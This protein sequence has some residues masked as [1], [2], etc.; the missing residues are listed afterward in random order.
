MANENISQQ[1]VR[2]AND[3]STNL[4]RAAV[5]AAQASEA[6]KNPITLENT[7]DTA[8]NVR[9]GVADNQVTE[10]NQQLNSATRSVSLSNSGPPAT[11]IIPAPANSN[12]GDNTYVAPY[13][14]SSSA[15]SD[16]II[17]IDTDLNI[18]T[19][20]TPVAVSNVIAGSPLDPATGAIAP[21]VDSRLPITE[22]VSNVSASAAPIPLKRDIIS[23]AE[24]NTG[25]LTVTTS[26]VISDGP[27]QVQVDSTPTSVEISRTQ[28]SADAPPGTIDFVTVVTKD[29]KLIDDPE[30]ATAVTVTPVRTPGTPENIQGT[31][32]TSLNLVIQQQI[33]I[34][35]P[36]ASDATA[37]P[38]IHSQLFAPDLNEVGADVLVSAQ[39]ATITNPPFDEFAGLD[40]AIREQELQNLLATLSNP[41]FDEF[42]GLDQAVDLQQALAINQAAAL[43]ELGINTGLSQ[44]PEV[45]DAAGTD[46]TDTP[47]GTLS[48][49][50]VTNT[51]VS[52]VAGDTAAR[53][54]VVTVNEKRQVDWRF[55]IHLSKDAKYLYK[56]DKISESNLLYPLRATGGVVF[57]YT[58]KIDVIYSANYDATEITHSNY[59]FYNYKNSSIDNINITGDFTAQDTNEANYMLAVIHFFRSVT[60][61]F[62]GQDQ[63][64]VAG[65]PPPLCYLSGHGAYAFDNHPVVITS[66]SLNYPQDVDYINARVPVRG[67]IEPP[68]YNRPIVGPPGFLQRIINLR[69]QGLDVGGVAVDPVFR[70]NNTTV[71]YGE[72]T[73][74][75]TKLSISISASAIVTRNDA[76]NNFS[77]RDYSSGKLM[78]SVRSKTNGKPSYGGFW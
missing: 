28:L 17:T 16:T 46:S 8:T 58:P 5:T 38:L 62:Y 77:L 21:V 64:P 36:L 33:A 6:T 44:A 2:V 49:T 74:V 14:P 68:A 31:A 1:W 39:T 30:S 59:K 69:K 37:T 35:T 27:I 60:K 56:D 71:D 52:P 51:A 43:G 65:T 10:I 34:D 66:F 22:P 4:G 55:K 53:L 13:T 54:P 73:R 20:V 61:M 67:S 19:V 12:P 76:S 40:Q 78:R 25:S 9:A 29:I 50:D 63:N 47:T 3:L 75:P 24:E 42:A 15:I 48:A 45:T 70:A 11:T 7:T 41:P 26:T 72:L 18:G 23:P 57:P 32:D